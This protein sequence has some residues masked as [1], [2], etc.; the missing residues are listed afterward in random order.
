MRVSAD[1]VPLAGYASKMYDTRA[2]RIDIDAQTYTPVP[3]IGTVQLIDALAVK[4]IQNSDPTMP[5]LPNIAGT[6]RYSRG[7]M[8]AMSVQPFQRFVIFSLKLDVI[9]ETMAPTTA[10]M[11]AR[12]T[13]SRV[14]LYVSAKTAGTA[15]NCTAPQS[16]LFNRHRMAPMMTHPLEEYGK[17]QGQVE[18]NHYDDGLADRHGQRGNQRRLRHFD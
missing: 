15:M 8:L 9:A 3:M 10:A 2:V 13:W 6:S 18:G 14:K 1:S 7:A 17:V 16:A 11:K 12:P 4:P 5:M